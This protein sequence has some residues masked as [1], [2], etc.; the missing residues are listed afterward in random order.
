MKGVFDHEV[1]KDDEEVDSNLK[2]LKRSC[3]KLLKP[4]SGKKK[5]S[6]SRI[7][8]IKVRLNPNQSSIYNYFPKNEGEEQ[9]SGET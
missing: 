6:G 8:M 7:S 4:S 1:E 2:R 9:G 5:S 3:L